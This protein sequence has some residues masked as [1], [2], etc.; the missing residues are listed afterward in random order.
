MQ[1]TPIN[2]IKE[3][4]SI[5]LGERKKG[6]EIYIVGDTETTG[7]IGSNNSINVY[8]KDNP[9][10][11]GKMHRILEVG[12]VFCR[13]NRENGSLEV[14]KDANGGDIFFH[15][16]INPFK[17]DMAKK[18]SLNSIDFVPSNVIYVHGITKKFLNGEEGIN[19]GDD[20]TF[21]LN[22]PAPTFQE[23]INPF[24][25]IST[26]MHSRDESL[27]NVYA[28]FHNTDFDLTFMDAE[29]QNCHDEYELKIPRCQDLFLPFDTLKFFREMLPLDEINDLKEKSGV[30]KG[31]Y[32]LDTLVNIFTELGYM[33]NTYD[34]ELHGA[35]KDV[36]IT[37]D[38]F[39]AISKYKEE[40]K[41]QKIISKLEEKEFNFSDMRVDPL[42]KEEQVSNYKKNSGLSR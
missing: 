39:N 21:Q 41:D 26:I 35:Y 40:K 13:R 20:E 16:Y 29:M 2:K 6:N 34:R 38:V 15:E 32:S 22:N 30:K 1:I 7:G 25:E 8:E 12:F 14:L 11:K 10:C 17:E 37:I 19:I 5:V 23:I 27:P 18:N 9:D 36:L 24:L 4:S 3:W 28:T 33:E 42:K 31:R